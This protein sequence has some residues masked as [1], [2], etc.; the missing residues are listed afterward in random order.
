MAKIY[1]RYGTMRSGK[2]QDVIRAYDSYE[3]SDRKSIIIK[4]SIDT[5]DEGVVSTRKGYN[6]KANILHN[7]PG[8]IINL[9]NQ[10]VRNNIAV[11]AVIVDEAQFLSPM[12]IQEL[13]VI[14]DSIN[15]PVLAYGLKTNFRGELFT[16]SKLLIEIADNIEEIKTV[17]QF[18]NRKATMNLR[19]IN[20]NGEMYGAALEGNE[21]EIGDEEYIQTCREHFFSFVNGNKVE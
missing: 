3:K 4:P 2:S 21:I 11:H 16:G 15:I 14:A 17:C 1:Y 18:C 20:N 19:V 7:K 10:E 9:I 8:E 6:V 13:I 5:R 12:Q